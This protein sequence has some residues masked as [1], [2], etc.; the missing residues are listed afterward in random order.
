MSFFQDRPASPNSRDAANLGKRRPAFGSSG[1]RES[2][3]IWNYGYNGL[4]A[5][6]AASDFEPKKKDPRSHPQRPIRSGA[7]G[8]GVDHVSFLE[9]EDA[10]IIF[11]RRLGLPVKQKVNE[12]QVEQVRLTST[13]RHDFTANGF[14]VNEEAGKGK[15][16]GEPTKRDE[17]CEN[18]TRA[19]KVPMQSVPPWNTGARVLEQVV[20]YE[21]EDKLS[22]EEEQDDEFAHEFVG[23]AGEC[24]GMDY[25][26]VTALKG[27]LLLAFGDFEADES[28]EATK[29]A[30]GVITAQATNIKSPCNA[31]KSILS[32]PSASL[33]ELD[34]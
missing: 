6:T 19:A 31:T 10:E 33:F 30:A 12:Q 3:D 20:D 4:F 16:A 32:S 23:C 11:R 9:F 17:E 34:P 21:S 28:E 13:H 18:T 5:T 22:G 15:A 2:E 29:M 24:F 14:I 1:H 27:R 26:A 8:A 7:F 25:G